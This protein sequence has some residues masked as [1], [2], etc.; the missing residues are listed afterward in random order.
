M[1]NILTIGGIVVLVAAIAIPVLA[2]GPGRGR[3]RHMMDYGQ[4]DPGYGCEGDRG[5]DRLTEEQR[6]K[7][8]E[9]YRKFSDE[10]A[11]LRDE[12]RAKSSELDTLLNSATPDAGKAK[13][14]Q[15]EISDLKTKLDEERLN[16][17]L[18]ARKNNPDA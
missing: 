2:H 7:S 16:Y 17:K 11:Q 13:A 18:E 1:R 15:K 12:I 4:G 9:L 8:D 5:Y 3:G 6:S 14:L 10:T